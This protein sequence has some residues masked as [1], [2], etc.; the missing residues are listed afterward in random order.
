MSF[1]NENAFA[2]TSRLLIR[3]WRTEEAD[4]FYDMHRRPE[5]AQ[6]IGGTPMGTRSEALAVIERCSAQLAD[7]PRF[8]SWA[9][10]ERSSGVPAGTV[11]LKPLPDAQGE[12]EIGWHLH[13]DRWGHGFA[14]EAAAALL[15]RAFADGLDEVWAVT[16]LD[17]HRSVAVCRKLGMRLLGVTERWYHEPVLMFW[18]GRGGDLEPSLEP[19]RAAP[20]DAIALMKANGDRPG[21]R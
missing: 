20:S 16:H 17:N 1:L 2:T 7:D 12:I 10:V 15:A 14:T 11:L 6:W 8:G 13:P 4:R 21:G 9:V 3:P 18:A 5:V 19:D